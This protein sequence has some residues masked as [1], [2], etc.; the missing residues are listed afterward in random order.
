MKSIE[1]LQTVLEYL[2]RSVRDALRT[3]PKE[4]FSRIQEIRLRCHRPAGIVIRNQENPVNPGH[5]LTVDEIMQS[6]Q[7]VCSYSVYSHEQELSEGYITIRGGCR[8][9]ICGTAVRD[10]QDARCVKSLKYISSLN[11]RIAGEFPGIAEQLWKQ[12][13]GSILIAGAVA[14]GKTTYLRDLCKIA[15]NQYRTALI[16]E[17]GELAAVRMGVPQHDIGRMTDVLDGYPRDVGILTALRVLS[18]EYIVCDEISTPEDVQAILQASGCGVRF[19]A[20]CH[21]GNPAEITNRQFIK[22]LLEQNIFQY[23]V[24]LERNQIRTVRKLAVS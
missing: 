8:V 12:V 20:S 21:A 9:G 2:P 4:E 14:S 1:N 22:P 19:L 3:I 16:D 10:G 24:F 23:L 17:R 11:F 18:P 15:G 7:A 6:F 13:S 5:V